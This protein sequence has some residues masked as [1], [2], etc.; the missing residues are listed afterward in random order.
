MLP[1]QKSYIPRVA[2]LINSLWAYDQ[3]GEYFYGTLM[4]PSMLRAEKLSHYFINMSKKVK[5]ES[6]EKRE[7]KDV[8]KNDPG[9]SKFDKFKV[10]YQANKKLNKVSVADL[11]DVS[12]E[13]IYKWVKKIDNE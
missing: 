3:P 5:I 4:E 6:A 12:R 11:L 9:K 10:M 8:I 13:C 2:M 1:K 7:L